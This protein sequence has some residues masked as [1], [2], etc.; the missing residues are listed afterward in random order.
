MTYGGGRFV[1]AGTDFTHKSS[2]VV[3]SAD[4]IH[5]DTVTLNSQYSPFLKTVY[6]GGTYLV[7]DGANLYS[8][9]DATHWT[10]VPTPLENVGSGLVYGNGKFVMF[11]GS[12]CPNSSK[13]VLA[14]STDGKTWK[15]IKYSTAFGKG[16]IAFLLGYDGTR[17]VDIG[18]APV[19]ES[20]LNESSSGPV[21]TPVYTSCDGATWTHSADIADA[22]TL[23][24]G[25]LQVTGDGLVAV[26][27]DE[28]VGE[29]SECDDTPDTTVIGMSTDSSQWAVTR[30]EDD[31]DDF[32]FEHLV[33]A[34]GR[35]YSAFPFAD[36]TEFLTG[37]GVTDWSQVPGLPA[38]ANTQ[39]VAAGG[40]RIVVAGEKG[41][42]FS[43]PIADI[44]VPK[45]GACHDLPEV[46]S[47]GSSGSFDLL[48]LIALLGLLMLRPREI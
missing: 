47:G 4:G 12:G 32:T 2:S 13:C 31:F 40:G 48:S 41:E 17:F 5:W 45:G 24:F 21:S 46:S 38:T 18:D 30:L 6:G 44:S 43:A 42:I 3:T 39:T 1:V 27:S 20:S 33:Q 22:P 28:C 7:A 8:S 10:V 36:G 35:Y 34:G 23:G 15:T 16:V 25:T 29:P 9:S 14:T 11:S 37:A 19:D 26:G